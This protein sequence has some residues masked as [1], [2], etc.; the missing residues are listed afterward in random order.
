MKKLYKNFPN[1]S[2]VDHFP[3]SDLEHMRLFYLLGTLV[4]MADIKALFF[5]YD[6]NEKVFKCKV[7]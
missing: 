4:K 1:K 7:D 2:N 6:E 3:F 5:A